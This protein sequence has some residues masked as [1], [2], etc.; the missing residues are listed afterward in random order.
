MSASAFL[1]LDRIAAA[2]PDGTRLFQDLTLAIG[3][4]RVGLVGRNGAGKSTLLAIIAGEA[5]PQAGSLHRAGR[6]GMLAQTLPGQG[7][8]AQALGIA[9]A[10][11]RLDR[12]EAGQ[13]SPED[14][15][16][17]DWT[18]RERLDGALADAGL[19]GL[20]PHRDVASLSGGERT[21][22]ALAAMLLPGPDLLLLDEPTNNLDEEGRQAVATLLARWP[23]G[24]LVASHDRGLLEGMD[25]IVQ[26]AP[27]GI[28]TVTGGWSD[29]IAVRNAL[30]E[31]ADSDLT[32]ARQTLDQQAR[33]AQQQAERQ[34]RRD[35]AGRAVKARGD[36][37][38]ILL[39]KRADQAEQSGGR[40]R[41]AAQAR[42]DEARRAVE[43]AR[44]HVDVLTPLQIDLPSSGLPGNRT[45][46]RME[47]VVL[48][49][50]GRRLFG[51]LSLTITG[52]CR[53]AVEGRNGSGKSSLLALITGALQPD[54][55]CIHRVAPAMAMLDQHAA[56][57]A[58]Q[59]DLL[60]NLRAHHPGLTVGEAHA[61][62]A[63]FAFRNRDARKP[64]GVLSGGERLRAALA[65]V[66]AGPTPPQLLI[67]DE[68]TNHLDV[69][70]I[71]IL[72]DALR[73]WDGALMLVS[74]DAAFLDRIGID[75]R[76]RLGGMETQGG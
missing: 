9:P 53:I 2:R 56:L 34:A 49:R 64:A 70:S 25:R 33:A 39:G 45:L 6:I 48:S 4:E 60:D 66:M 19:A 12:L 35:K 43:S 30:K 7:S 61:V 38:R 55:G 23:G 67:L 73:R 74:H 62:L 16:E 46:L 3:R 58:P 72:E 32:R 65:I 18:L 17:A 51:P 42:I 40:G 75:E 21:R 15:A 8:V 69:E 29:F 36:L 28:V 41:R 54:S 47:D 50:G 71:E 20:P 52:P 63:R 59:L 76:V 24:A 57:L 27:S 37:P 26:L 68:P 5:Q 14:A 11:A 22:L 10:L 31:Q 1:T 44:Q 13:G